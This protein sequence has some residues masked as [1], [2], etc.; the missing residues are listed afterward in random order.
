VRHPQVGLRHLR[1]GL[2]LQ[3]QR[4]G[5]RSVVAEALA[6]EAEKVDRAVRHLVSAAADGDINAAKALIPWIDQGLG[7]PT[8]RVEHRR[9]SS[10][11]ELE[12][13]ETSELERLVAEGRRKRIQAQG[14]Q[15]VPDAPDWRR[16]DPSL[17]VVDGDVD[18]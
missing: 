7:K 14:L 12:A 8:E 17:G 15:A 5:T 13:M 9:P 1:L 4:L 11:E 10:L 6:S 3:L 18:G 16:R 2:V